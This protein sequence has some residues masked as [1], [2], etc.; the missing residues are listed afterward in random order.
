[1]ALLLSLGLRVFLMTS[2]AGPICFRAGGVDAF[3]YCLILTPPL[4]G[5]GGELFPLGVV[6]SVFNLLPVSRRTSPSCCC[7]DAAN[8]ASAAT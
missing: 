4:S 8:A 7:R 3:S 5:D 1:M 2:N 6:A